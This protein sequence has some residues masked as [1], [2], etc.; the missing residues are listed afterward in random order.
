MNIRLNW[1]KHPFFTKYLLLAFFVSLVISE[2]LN[3]WIKIL[4]VVYRKPNLGYHD[5]PAF[6]HYI[7]WALPWV[8]WVMLATILMLDI[9]KRDFVRTGG[10]VTGLVLA[11]VAFVVLVVLRYAVVM[12]E[13]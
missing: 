1:L 7:E 9:R 12:S 4:S 5:L 3:W 6:I 10:F 13:F 2:I 8:V 11:Y